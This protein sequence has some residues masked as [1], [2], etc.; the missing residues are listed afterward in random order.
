M[1]RVFRVLTARLK[2]ILWEENGNWMSPVRRIYKYFYISSAKSL[3]S[4][5]R[6]S[7]ALKQI[8]MDNEDRSK[9]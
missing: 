7:P 3:I 2:R 8:R 9:M 6:G 1:E 4:V 5:M